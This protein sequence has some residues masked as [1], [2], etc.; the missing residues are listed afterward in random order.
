M[1]IRDPVCGMAIGWEEATDY[2]VEGGH[3]YYFCCPGCAGRFRQDRTHYRGLP[4]P[5]ESRTPLA[6]CPPPASPRTWVLPGSRGHG[7]TAVPV[8]SLPR[9]GPVTLDQLERLVVQEWRRRL[10][11]DGVRRLQARIL[12]RGLLSLAVATPDDHH[13]IEVALAAEVARLRAP[14]LEGQRVMTELLALPEAICAALERVGVDRPRAAAMMRSIRTSVNEVTE[15]LRFD[16]SECRR[17]SGAGVG[18]GPVD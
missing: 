4:G 12:E 18:P 10:G 16:R 3:V 13:D 15:W 9:V 1:Q 14:G 7:L 17:E 11:S 5:G 6:S 2:V 8:A